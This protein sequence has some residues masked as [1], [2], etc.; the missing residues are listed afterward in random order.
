MNVKKTALLGLL[1]VGAV[2]LSMGAY[3]HVKALLAQ[4]LLEKSWQ[5]SKITQQVVKPWSW[6]DTY[7]LARLTV[8]KLGV[9]LIVLSGASGRTMAFAPAH[10]NGTSLPNQQGSIVLTGHRDT[11]FRFLQ[12]IKINDKI[13]LE[14][15]NG[16]ITEYQVVDTQI[17][18]QSHHELLQPNQESTLILITC[19]PFDGIQPNTEWRYV[20]LAK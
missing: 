4:Y 20:V 1:V 2:Y 8:Q 14:A 13:H 15:M 6:A 3:I 5:Q 16:G 9:N 18:H 19:Y 11:H 17:V 12:N 7:P 10:V